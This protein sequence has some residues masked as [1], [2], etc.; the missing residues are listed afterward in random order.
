VE[1][2]TEVFKK[3]DLCRISDTKGM[4]AMSP[5]YREMLVQAGQTQTSTDNKAG[6]TK[7]LDPFDDPFEYFSSFKHD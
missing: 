5:V 1:E 6:K 3:M 2:C 4:Q 7:T